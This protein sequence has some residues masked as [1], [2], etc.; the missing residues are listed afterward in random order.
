MILTSKTKTVL[1]CYK[2][3]NLPSNNFF[4]SAQVKSDENLSTNAQVKG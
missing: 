1:L 2:L 4:I 3:E